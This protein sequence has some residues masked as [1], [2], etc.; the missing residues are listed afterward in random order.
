[1]DTRPAHRARQRVNPGEDCL[2]ECGMR[3]L[4]HEERRAAWTAREIGLSP[5]ARRRRPGAL[6]SQPYSSGADDSVRRN[7]HP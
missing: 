7:V 5:G 2:S 3:I 1:M 4:A 6:R